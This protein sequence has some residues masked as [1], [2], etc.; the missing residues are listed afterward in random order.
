MVVLDSDTRKREPNVLRLSVQIGDMVGCLPSKMVLGALLFSAV[1]GPAQ[2][3]RRSGDTVNYFSSWDVV[4]ITTATWPYFFVES[5]PE[6]ANE[7]QHRL[8]RWAIQFNYSLI[9]NS[10]LFLFVFLK[11][12]LEVLL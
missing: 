3:I 8:F 10:C 7:G 5:R 4:S 1:G 12:G 9:I 6:K 2:G 11:K